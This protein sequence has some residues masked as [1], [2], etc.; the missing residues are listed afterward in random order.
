MSGK[1]EKKLFLLY[2]LVQIYLNLKIQ[3]G[4]LSKFFSLHLIFNFNFLT[5]LSMFSNVKVNF[6]INTIFISIYLIL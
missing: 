3:K 6:Y 1:R 2:F 5:F 4:H